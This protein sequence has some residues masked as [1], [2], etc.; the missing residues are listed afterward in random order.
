MTTDAENMSDD[1]LPLS[2][3]VPAG[4]SILHRKL[5]LADCYETDVYIHPPA[6]RKTLLPILYV[7]GIQSHPGWFSGSAASLAGRGHAVYQVTRRGSGLNDCRRGHAESAQCLLDDLETACRFVLEDAGSA[8]LQRKL[9]LM[10]V[11]WGG[12]LAALYAARP[13]YREHLASLT[14]I[15]PGIVPRVKASVAMKLAVVGALF[16]SPHKYFDIPLNDVELFTDNPAMRQYLHDDQYRICRATAKFLYADH[17]LNRMLSRCSRGSLDI[18]TT[19]LLASRDHIIDN[20]ATEAVVEH[21]ADGRAV[22]RELNGCHT[23]EFEDNPNPLFE[24]L[25]T[26]AWQ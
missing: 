9:H 14:L 12:K 13:Q 8:N 5:R 23:L 25:S 15:A 17:C 11:S 4:R 22:V 16:M 10:G 1:S 3:P 18:P 20:A 6:G 24:A 21:L 26:A 19:L 2:R 7:H